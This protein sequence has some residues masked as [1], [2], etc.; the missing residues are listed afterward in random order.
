MVSSTGARAELVALFP[1]VC[2]TERYWFRLESVD[3]AQD[4][5]QMRANGERVADPHEDAPGTMLFSFVLD[6][7][8][9]RAL[10]R[11]GRAHRISLAALCDVCAI[12]QNH[13]FE[14]PVTPELRFKRG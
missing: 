7:V 5:L 9:I 6:P 8:E 11:R 14:E 13:M 2:S 1:S 3:L 10:L 12:A 4:R